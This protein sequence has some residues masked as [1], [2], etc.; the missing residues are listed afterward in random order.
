MLKPGFID[1][2]HHNTIPESLAPAKQSG[3]QGVIHKATEG[4]SYVDDK[5]DNR[6]Y[7]ARDAGMLWGVYHFARPGDMKQQVDHFLRTT[8]EYVDEN[9]LY[10]LDWEDAG[11]LLDEVVEFMERLERVVETSPVLYSGHVV[12]EA[13]GGEGD[14]RLSKY[15]LWVCQYANAP[16][17]PPGWSKYWG[18][19]YTDQGS[20]PGINAPVD[21][22]A[23]DG[24]IEQLASTWSGREIEPAPIP[25]NTPLTVTILVP[26]GVQVTVINQRS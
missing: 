9:S 1:L 14:P 11:V 5:L 16:V 7:L 4:S 10:A 25:P 18:W 23:F 20:C 8:A 2:S 22:N 26:P 19:Q 3:I 21:L 24:S 17:L 6:Y 15:R 12:K 13:L